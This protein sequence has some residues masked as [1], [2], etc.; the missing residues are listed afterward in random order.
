MKKIVI[1]KSGGGELANQLWNYASIYA[2]GL[3]TGAV[4]CNPAFFEYHS[5]FN[6]LPKES[7]PTRFV[8]RFFRTARRRAHV[9][10]RFWRFC[11]AISN[12]LI[13]SLH[14]SC[15]LSS[16]NASNTPVYLPP[17]GPLQKSSC[18]TLY[19]S[20]W[21]F[22][23]PEGLKKYRSELVRVFA[24]RKEIG[25]KVDDIV[26][27]LRKNTSTLLGLHIRQGDYKV[28]KG[29]RYL[30]SAQRMRELVEEYGAQHQL[31]PDNM[32]L[33]ITSDG[34]VD[35]GAFA[36]FKVYRSQEDAVT[37]L[38]LLSRCD[39]VIGSDSSFGNFAAWY[40]DTPHI[41]ATKEPIDWEYYRGKQDYFENKYCTLV[42][43]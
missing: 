25:T 24:P 18:E 14:V 16:Q 6:F 41:V 15:T 4:V 1:Q 32:Q 23:N 27:P 7:L 28:F 26:S 40:G 42:H 9:I 33:L 2:Y 5:F 38:F 3:E 36:G 13:L 22:R 39:A 21:L 17:T 8:A 34:P 10:N 43:F 11:V 35:M 12:N 37:D 19:F 20:G 31:I 30:I 29:G